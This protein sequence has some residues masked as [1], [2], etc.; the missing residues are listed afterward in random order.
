M[1]I[2]IAGHNLANA[3]AS[4][5]ACQSRQ[6]HP[7]LKGDLLRWRGNGMKVI[8][9]P[10][11]LIPILIGC[12]GYIRHRFVGFNGILDH[13]QVHFPAVGNFDTLLHAFLLSLKR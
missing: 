6:R 10:D 3:D 13:R 9:H 8:N 5:V 7:G 11:G 1:A 12:L 4:R 2:A